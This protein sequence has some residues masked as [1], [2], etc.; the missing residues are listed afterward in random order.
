MTA[1]VVAPSEHQPQPI[2]TTVLQPESEG[3]DDE[4]VMPDDRPP[5]KK[6]A[7][8]TRQITTEPSAEAKLSAE[9]KPTSVPS[10]SEQSE[11]ISSLHMTF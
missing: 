8:R 5:V 10:R 4:D 11:I 1:A 6:R 3:S 2:T 9:T 7:R